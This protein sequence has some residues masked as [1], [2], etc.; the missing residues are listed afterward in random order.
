MIISETEIRVRYVETDQM[1][2]VYYG[3]YAQ[4][5]EIGRVEAF[6][7][8]GTSYKLLEDS[9]IMMPVVSMVINYKRPA[10]YDDILTIKT[11]IKELPTTRIRFEYEIYNQNNE[12]INTA[13]TILVFV[14]R[15]N[16][17]PCRCPQWFLNL[18][19]D[20]NDNL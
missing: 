6:R 7:Q 5:Y 8:L 16:M 4:Y 10:L 17:K 2:Y 11:I 13:E 12:L 1:S 20:F 15:T 3:N 18:F 14:N 19:P 9:G